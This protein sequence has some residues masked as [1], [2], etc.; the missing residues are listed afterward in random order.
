M[1]LNH[2]Q[3]SVALFLGLAV[4]IRVLDVPA[5][6]APKPVFKNTAKP[7]LRQMKGPRYSQSARGGTTDKLAFDLR[8][9]LRQYSRGRGA[10]SSVPKMSAQTI[11]RRYGISA[12]DFNPSVT[13]AIET[14]GSKSV[15][16]NLRNAG[17]QIQSRVGDTFYV[18]VAVLRLSQISAIDGVKTI[19]PLHAP[20]IPKRPLGRR[21]PAGLKL[22]SRGALANTFDHQGLTGKGVI[23][24]VIDS[25]IDW[26]HGDFLHANGTTRILALYDMSD[27]SWTKSKGKI[28]TKPPLSDGKNR[29]ERFIHKSKSTMR[30][31]AIEYSIRSIKSVME[32]RVREL[33]PETERRRRMAF[34]VAF[35]RVSR[36][37]PI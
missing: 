8:L 31:K 21:A 7:N 34:R 28:G 36:P 33:L 32:R 17:A 29:W 26:K 12:G 4:G 11:Q 14:N 25:G 24:G 22:R 3:K 9:L 1:K 35:I 2:L 18:N 20:Q 16:S 10:P 19:S 13:V 6:A 5:Q 37:K 23:V 30:S 15:A 27:D